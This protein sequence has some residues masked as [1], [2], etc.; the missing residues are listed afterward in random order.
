MKEEIEKLGQ[1]I[2]SLRQKAS[3][4]PEMEKYVL[5]W[6]HD[7]AYDSEDIVRLLDLRDIVKILSDERL[8]LIGL[9]EEE[10]IEEDQ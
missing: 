7:P 10:D 3:G 2:D 6:L 4:N 1:I 9:L 5:D 8:N